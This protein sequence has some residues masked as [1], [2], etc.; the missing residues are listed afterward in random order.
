MFGNGLDTAITNTSDWGVSST[1][2]SGYT[3]PTSQAANGASPWG[4][5]A[6]SIDA[7]AHWIWDSSYSTGETVYF[8]IAINAVD[9]V[10]A[11]DVPEPTS[12]AILSLA[13]LGFGARR[14]KK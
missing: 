13:L 7:N 3:L 10:D 11:V 5:Y 14:F 6:S 4:N 12:L 8:S 1:G 2:W 9:A